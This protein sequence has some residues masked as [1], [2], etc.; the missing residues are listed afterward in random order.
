MRTLAATLGWLLLGIAA[1]SAQTPTETVEYYGQDVIGS[2]RMVFRPD[3]TVVARQDY[4]PFGRALF[5]VPAMPTEGFGSQEKDSETH[6]A[7]FHARM[8]SDSIGR[9]STPDPVQDGVAEPQRWNRYAYALNNPVR[10]T[11]WAGMN[12]D[13]CQDPAHMDGLR[14]YASSSCSEMS[15]DMKVWLLMAWLG[16]G[17]WSGS[18]GGGGSWDGGGGG[19]G[20]FPPGTGGDNTGETTDQP[21]IPPSP[22]PPGPTPPAPPPPGPPPPVGYGNYILQRFID[23]FPK[24]CGGG[25]F[26]YAGPAI[27]LGKLVEMETVGFAGFDSSDGWNVGGLAG[28]GAAGHVAGYEGG[29]GTRKGWHGSPVGLGVHAEGSGHAGWLISAK[30]GVMTVAGL[31][32]FGIGGAG[33]SVSIGFDCGK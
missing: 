27:K 15:T 29:Y 3:G 18:G 24:L 4:E 16:F 30:D 20:Y 9:F 21:P 14:I 11:D 32:G 22:N 8:M 2:I 13:S 1:A 28:V 19:G 31:V 12:A 17:S 23:H 10:Y 26:G 25:A 6:Q 5:A 33:G 7:Y